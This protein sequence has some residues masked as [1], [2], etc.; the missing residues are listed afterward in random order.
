MINFPS[1]PTLN[2]THAEGGKTWEWNG[3]GWRLK[4]GALAVGDIADNTIALAKLVTV[5]TSSLLGRVTAGTGNVEVLTASQARTL[6]NVANGATANTGTVT[7]VAGGNGLT[8]TV[9]SSGSLTLGTPSNITLASTNSVTATSHTH[10]FA[11]GGTTA[12]YIRGDGSLATFPSVPTTLDSLTNVTI[13]SNTS[14][15][16]LKWNGSAWVNNTLAEAGIQPAGSYLT[17]NQTITLSGDVTGSGTTA[18]TATISNNTVTL[19]KMADIATARIIG[20]VT[21]GTGDPESLT[22]TQVT[23]LLDVFTTS[24]KGV[25]PASG[26]GTTN[27]LRADGTWAAPPGGGGGGSGTVTSVAAGNGL[28]F[29]T[30]T[31]SG[32]VTLGTPSTITGSSTNSVTTTSHTHALTLASGDITGALGYTPYNSTNPSGYTTNTGTVTSVSG[33]NGLT[34]SVTTSGSLALGTPS[35]CTA[36]TSNAV[37]STSHTHAITGFAPTSHSHAIS[38]VTGLQTALNS[39]YESGSTADL[40]AVILN[41]GPYLYNS[42]S[43]FGVRVGTSPSY[44]FFFFETD[45]TLNVNGGA[46]SSGNISCGT[47]TA[48]GQITSASNITAYSSD[49]RLKT[50]AKN[51]PNALEKLSNING[52]V[53]DWDKDACDAAGFTPTN[54]TEHGV[55]A[56]E[57]EKVIPDAVAPAPF[58]NDYKTVRYER[59]VPL[60]IEAIKEQQKQIDELKKRLGD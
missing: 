44:K 45:G 59:L 34:G 31:T 18:I 3:T 54:P 14:G 21:A 58:N 55:I 46:I 15:E 48:A 16:I 36:S 2:D 41:N 6:L 40:F 43:R 4:Y 24:L 11:P 60:L 47:I 39:K 29:A 38:D 26:G 28:D 22:G 37:T 33:G 12:Q 30:I 53:Y 35:T 32:S 51:I 50:N 27:F 17:A 19:A 7:S 9:T 49:G 13:T 1:S 25:V 10:A 56:Q 42:S 8:G 52:Y 23:T 5:P 57:I 20:R